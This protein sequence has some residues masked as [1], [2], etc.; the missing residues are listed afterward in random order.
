MRITV[1]RT[2]ETLAGDAEVAGS[3]VRRLVGLIGRN[4]MP[5]G[6]ALVLPGCRQV[7][8]ILMRFPIDVVFAD[9][10]WRVVRV[11][12]GL[13]PWR[14]GPWCG[15]AFYAVELPDG[16]AEGVQVGDRLLIEGRGAD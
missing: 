6:T 13:G 7:H 2:G 10:E 11:V 16:G 1:E 8:T 12:R 9:T 3:V 14:V 4:E 15:G 5:P